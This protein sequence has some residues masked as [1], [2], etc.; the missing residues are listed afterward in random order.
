MKEQLGFGVVVGLGLFVG[1]YMCGSS[2]SAHTGP[3][4]TPTSIEA[5]AT[6]V[7]VSSVLPGFVA[8]ISPELIPE[9]SEAYDENLCMDTALLQ[10]YPFDVDAISQTT[11]MVNFY[12]EDDQTATL[13][14][15]TDAIVGM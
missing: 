2:G 6:N 12:L 15:S 10:G 4:I 9:K 8:C 3:V 5:L 11:L 1:L 14:V 7:Q 13:Y